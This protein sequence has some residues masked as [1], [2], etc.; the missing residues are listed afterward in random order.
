MVTAYHVHVVCALI[1]RRATFKLE[2][3]IALI[4]TKSRWLFAAG[5]GPGLCAVDCMACANCVMLRKL[6]NQLIC[7]S[8]RCRR[9]VRSVCPV[10]GHR[11]HGRTHGGH[12]ADT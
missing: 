11:T 6:L 10:A 12:N 8:V 7:M 2:Y 5:I 9:G 1:D 3:V 4:L